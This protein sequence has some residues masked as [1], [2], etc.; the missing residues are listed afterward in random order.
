VVVI[1]HDGGHAGVV[2]DA[3]HG[4]TQAVVKP[5]GRTFDGLAG[6]SGSTILGSGRVGLILDVPTLLRQAVERAPA[7]A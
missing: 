7:P 2:V 6:F 1:R 3:L 5:L 4:A